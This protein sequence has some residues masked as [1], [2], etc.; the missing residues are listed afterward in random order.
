MAQLSFTFTYTATDAAIAQALTDAFNAEQ[1]RLNPAWVDVTP[2][3]YVARLFKRAWSDAA[4]RYLR[5]QQDTDREAETA[6]LESQTS[7]A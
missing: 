3:Q 4:L 7:V 2:K 6:R 1:R 5:G